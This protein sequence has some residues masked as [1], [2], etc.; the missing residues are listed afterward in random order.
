MV[1]LLYSFHNMDPFRDAGTLS[2]SLQGA[3]RRGGRRAEEPGLLPVAAAF[4]LSRVGEA[5]DAIRESRLPGKV[6]L[7]G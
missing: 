7:T 2:G 3:N 5:I 4:S 6:L 1:A